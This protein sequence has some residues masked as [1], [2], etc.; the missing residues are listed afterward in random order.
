RRQHGSSAATGWRRN[1]VQARPQLGGGADTVTCGPLVLGI[2]H[3]HRAVGEFDLEART[4]EHDLGGCDNPRGLAVWS[5]EMIPHTDITHRGPTGGSGQWSIER[6]YLPDTGPCRDDDHLPRVQAVGDL[7]ELGEAGR[8][9]AR[10]AALRRD[11]VDL[12]HG[13]L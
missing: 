1:G 6:E 8:H 5:E 4:A 3:N 13:G 9:T 12:V 10:D 7:V 2:G 11:R